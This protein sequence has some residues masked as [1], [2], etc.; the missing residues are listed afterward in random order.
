M[1]EELGQSPSGEKRWAEL[2]D[3]DDLPS[4]VSYQ[5]QED[6]LALYQ[7]A[8]LHNGVIETIM[9]DTMIAKVVTAWSEEFGDPPK[10]NP[11]KVRDL[12]RGAYRILREKIQPYV[13]DL[14]FMRERDRAVELLKAQLSAEPEDSSG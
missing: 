4:K 13:E 9:Y 11:E 1:R 8:E 14:D 12:P 6:I 2:T 7:K 10:G 3:L 5:V